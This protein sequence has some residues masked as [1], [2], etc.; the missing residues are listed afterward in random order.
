MVGIGGTQRVAAVAAGAFV[1]TNLDD[2][3]VLTVLFGESKVRDTI[4]CSHRQLQP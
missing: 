3:M 1:A 4:R 2:I